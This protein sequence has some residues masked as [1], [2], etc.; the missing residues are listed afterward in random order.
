MIG[1]DLTVRTL[2]SNSDKSGFGCVSVVYF[3]RN[4]LCGQSSGTGQ[5]G[6]VAGITT[7]S[8][9]DQVKIGLKYW[10]CVLHV[11]ASNR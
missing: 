7:E 11:L 10:Q 5:K 9:R 6:K 1:I 3:V 2:Y 4:R 8:N